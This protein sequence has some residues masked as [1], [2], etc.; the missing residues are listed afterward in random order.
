MLKTNGIGFIDK[1]SVQDKIIIKMFC[2]SKKVSLRAK[3]N[4]QCKFMN[5]KKINVKTPIVFANIFDPKSGDKERI[6]KQKIIDNLF[7][8]KKITAK[9]TRAIPKPGS[10][11]DKYFKLKWL[12]EPWKGYKPPRLYILLAEKGSTD[13]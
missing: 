5:V 2:F 12:K 8:E 9:E 7:L 10:T 6:V 4:K 3:L 1:E 13:K 11:I